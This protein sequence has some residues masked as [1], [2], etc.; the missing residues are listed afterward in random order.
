[1]IINERDNNNN[2]N[3]AMTTSFITTKGFG[4]TVE[5][6]GKEERISP[7]TFL[8][9]EATETEQMQTLEREGKGRLLTPSS[10]DNDD[11]DD[12]DDESES[13][14]LGAK[15]LTPG[16]ELKCHVSGP[17]PGLPMMSS[18][19]QQGHFLPFSGPARD[20][21][22]ETNAVGI[23]GKQANFGLKGKDGKY[24]KKQPFVAVKRSEVAGNPRLVSL[25]G[26][27]KPDLILGPLDLTGK[28][29]ERRAQHEKAETFVELMEE[30]E[31][32][33]NIDYEQLC[34]HAL[35]KTNSAEVKRQKREK[36]KEQTDSENVDNDLGLRPTSRQ[37]VNFDLPPSATPQGGMR[38]S[39]LT[40]NRKSV[41]GYSKPPILDP[42][43]VTGASPR[44]KNSL[45]QL[46]QQSKIQNL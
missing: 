38:G 16:I 5:E 36:E 4:N 21:S 34:K 22:F 23:E 33:H 45:F 2:Y 26:S 44:A 43:R 15:M 12:D 10:L 24:F 31:E 28:R 18:L 19:V 30:L 13:N 40:P 29:M 6:K 42:A 39:K 9:R 17:P 35:P 32:K 27:T 7:P 14:Y 25:L 1:M 20:A 46:Q 11:D 8:L 41:N 3:N 37:N